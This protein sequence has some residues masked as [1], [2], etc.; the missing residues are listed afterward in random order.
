MATIKVLDYTLKR[1]EVEVQ[2]G[3]CIQDI[4]DRAAQKGAQVKGWTNFVVTRGSGHRDRIY[5]PTVLWKPEW[6]LIEVTRQQPGKPGKIYPELIPGMRFRLASVFS[7]WNN[8]KA[9]AGTIV[10]YVETRNV[11]RV[12]H[13]ERFNIYRVMEG[14][15]RGEEILIRVFSESDLIIRDGLL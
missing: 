14:D 5:D 11:W 1:T 2:Q 12:Y 4:M 8:H 9:Q 6:T 10:E 13:H 15:F 7:T 3:D